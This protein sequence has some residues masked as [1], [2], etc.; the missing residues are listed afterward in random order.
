M[1]D[2][3]DKEKQGFQKERLGRIFEESKSK[4]GS[5]LKE[6]INSFEKE[7]GSKAYE[8]DKE[9]IRVM[10]EKL[11]TE[12]IEGYRKEFIKRL[13]EDMEREGISVHDLEDRNSLENFNNIGN[14]NELVEAEMVAVSQVE[15]VRF[16][17][18][19]TKIIN[20]IERVLNS[21]PSQK[22]VQ[23]VKD[24]ILEFISNPNIYCQSTY[25]NRKSEV[26]NL[27]SKLENY[28]ASERPIVSDRF[29]LGVVL[30]IAAVLL[31]VIL[32]GV[33]FVRQR[34]KK[35]Y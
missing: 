34:S 8:N 23:E 13:K 10:K 2:A 7:R 11:A 22:E 4:S 9:K 29:S 16:D 31:L 35:R 1:I 26:Q 32:L 3:I 5:D 18:G 21:F 15:K 6:S 33:S 20:Q 14:P 12:N 25:S 27:L 17:K 28:S 24:K 30:P 19:L